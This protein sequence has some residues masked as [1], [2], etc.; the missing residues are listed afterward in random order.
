MNPLF[1]HAV[2]FVSDTVHRF[3]GGKEI[4]RV[5][6]RFA[7]DFSWIGAGEIEFSTDSADIVSYL[8]ERAPL[9]PPCD[10]SEEEFHLVNVTD[11]TCTVMGRY[12]VRTG[13]ESGMV[14]EEH[15]RCS[16]YLV[17]SD[18]RL[19][20]RHVHVSNPYQAMKDELYFPFEAGARSYEYLQR[21][22]RE[23]TQ[24][25][26]LERERYRVALLRDQSG[27]VVKTVGSWKGIT[28]ERRLIDDLVDQARRDPLTKLFNQGTVSDLVDR[29][30]PACLANGCGA[31]LVLDV[32][33]LKLVNDTLG[34]PVGDDLLVRVARAMESTLEGE[35]RVAARVGGDE[36][37]VFLPDADR[38]RAWAFACELGR[39]T[40]RL[41]GFGGPVTLSAGCALA[42]LDADMYAG[43]FCAADRALYQAKRAGKN[44]V[45]FAD[46]SDR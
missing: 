43:L 19:L 26:E 41:Q 25:L 28:D 42:G 18:G 12:R 21:L 17:E 11:R 40:G 2:E 36:F 44:R 14:L 15:Q 45:R 10:V 46:A 22:L 32:D 13:A 23:K 7:D 5:V 31:L 38:S 29:A 3:Y 6:E 8:V 16:Y 33:D 24:T 37:V 20:I 39:K 4:D 30:L 27:G 1:G 35:A 9:A 34:H